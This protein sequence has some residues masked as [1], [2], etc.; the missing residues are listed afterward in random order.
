MI[1]NF[2][3][4]MVASALI[5]SLLIPP[6]KVEDAKAADFNDGGLPRATENAPI[7]FL[8][9]KD[10]LNAPNT[11]YCGNFVTA[12][13]TERVRTGL[14]SKKTVTVGYN[15]YITVDIGFCTGGGDGVTLHEVFIDDVSVWTGTLSTEADFSINMPSLFG[16]AK[17]GGGFVTSHCRW[18]PGTMTQGKSSLIDAELGPGNLLPNYNGIAHLV[19]RAN[20][21]ESPQLRKIGVVASRFTNNLAIPD[22]KHI[23][24]GTTLNPAEVLYSTMVDNWTGMSVDPAMIDA[25]NFLDAAL[26]Y[27]DEANGCGGSLYTAK[28]GKAFAQDIATQVDSIITIDPSSNKMV[29]RPLRF[30][31]DPDAVS[32][33]NETSILS[34]ESFSQTLWT[35]L[36]SEVKVT[37]RDEDNAYNEATAVDQDLA[38]AGITGRL[39]SSTISMPLVRKTPLATEIAGRELNQLS[40]PATSAVLLFNR[41]GY[42]LQPGGVFR[43]SWNDFNGI[44]MIMRVK[45]AEVGSDEDGS[46][47]VEVTKDPYGEIYTTFASPGTSPTDPLTLMPDPVEIYF[48][49]D[50]HRLLVD[51]FT[52]ISGNSDPD[53][54]F[55]MLL[56]IRSDS[57]SL[58]VSAVVDDDE[59]LSYSNLAFPTWGLLK[60]SIGIMD[61]FAA[62]VLTS[63]TVEITDIPDDWVDGDE[64]TVREGG[65]LILV[66]GELMGFETFTDNL[67]GTVDLELVHRGLL[68]TKQQIH[69][70][71]VDVVFPLVDFSYISTS[72]S[73]ADDSPT[74]VKFLPSSGAVN[75]SSSEVTAVSVPVT[76]GYNKPDAPDYLQL[77]GSRVITE[78]DSGAVGIVATWR[79]RDRLFTSIRLIDEVADTAPSGM[80][81]NFYIFN[82]T[83][84]GAAIYT[85]LGLTSPTHTFDVPDDDA[86][87]LDTLEIRVYAVRSGMTSLVYDFYRFEVMPPILLLSGDGEPFELLLSGDAASGGLII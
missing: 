1:L 72:G 29:I 68:N 13:I 60:T 22:G 19:F 55:L 76:G 26:V 49:Y 33:F 18:F 85:E 80:T 32:M 4:I 82:I 50:T 75:L 3:L 62:G 43:W 16:G 87:Y 15:Y 35:D 47:R 28:A 7:A 39:K 84:G 23:I 79:P 45:K 8:V 70:A 6:I 2:L 66:N 63:I 34:V 9:G 71:D 77:D 58:S 11:I 20:I 25:D 36:V 46:I 81:W 31:Y 40:K 65:N 5:F 53:L 64:E 57:V 52:L 83:D 48:V 27:Y 61:G 10:R 30:D 37:F 74:P 38:V 54:S 59:E 44:S 73:Y 69:T 78:L 86:H 21:G 67:D 24:G 42:K 12:A 56:P 17:N 41:K 51:S 14:F